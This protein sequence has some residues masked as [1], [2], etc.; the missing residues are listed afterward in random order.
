[1]QAGITE[2]STYAVVCRLKSSPPYI[3]TPN[4]G[5]FN[6]PEYPNV[7]VT[8]PMNAV[9]QE[10]QIPLQIKVGLPV[11]GSGFEGA[12]L[13]YLTRN[14]G[15]GYS[16]GSCLC[17]F[18]CVMKSLRCDCPGISHRLFWREESV[19]RFQCSGLLIL[20]PARYVLKSRNFAF[21]L[22]F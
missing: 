2:C 14:S 11:R 13:P 8:I 20:P 19:V 10:A 1:M 4:G 22:L 6:L 9:A 5:S 18:I 12:M 15:S 17:H 16:F 3:I 7:C 21:S